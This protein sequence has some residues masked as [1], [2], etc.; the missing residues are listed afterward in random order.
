MKTTNYTDEILSSADMVDGHRERALILA[1]QAENLSEAIALAPVNS[2][3]YRRLNQQLGVCLKLA[4]VHAH[5]AL[6]VAG[7]SVYVTEVKR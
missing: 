7:P 3:T 5:L 4:T 2:E 6:A 1:D